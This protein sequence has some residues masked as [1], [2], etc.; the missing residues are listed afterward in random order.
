MGRE[1]FPQSAPADAALRLIWLYCQQEQNPQPAFLR[2]RTS[3]QEQQRA[4]ALW[5]LWQRKPKSAV[6]L[7]YALRDFGL[8]RVKEYRLL[9]DIDPAEWQRA[10]QS[11]WELRQL[12]IGGQQLI[13]LGCPK[14]KAVGE[15]LGQLLSLCIEGKLEN[16]SCALRLEARRRIKAQFSKG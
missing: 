7:R 5:A 8:Q 2:L 14:G 4:A 15:L 12:S 16:T 6:Q 10:K 3:R 11:C 13:E 9:C 1:G